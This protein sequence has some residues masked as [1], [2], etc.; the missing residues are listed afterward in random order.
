MVENK[1][2]LLTVKQQ[3]K[4]LEMFE[5][6]EP[7]SEWAKDYIHEMVL[8]SWSLQNSF[9]WWQQLN[10]IMEKSRSRY[11]PL[12]GARYVKL[13]DLTENVEEIGITL[14]WKS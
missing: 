4:L 9:W 6:G 3:F 14:K 7:A 2:I 5:N 13:K 1:K 8:P 12:L 11:R 10:M